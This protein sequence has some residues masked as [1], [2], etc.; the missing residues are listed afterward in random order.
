MSRDADA[1]VWAS[2]RQ[3]PERAI[4]GYARSNRLA[5]TD[6][7][8]AL[9]L[10]LRKLEVNG[11]HFRRQVVVGGYIA[12]FACRRARLV[13]EADGGQH[14]ENAADKARTIEMEALGWRV[15][16]FWNNDILRNPA[17]VATQVMAALDEQRRAFSGTT[18][19][20]DPSPQGGGE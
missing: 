4:D 16:R 10:L 12:D 11:S 18:P 8:R 15:L 7:E 19:T 2:T 3:S 13:I 6:A 9:W 17:G 14:C 5:P 20:P 1:R